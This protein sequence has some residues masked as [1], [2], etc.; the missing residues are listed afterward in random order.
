MPPT[1][2][3][4]LDEKSAE[5]MCCLFHCSW[6]K[7]QLKSR[8]AYCFIA[9]GWKGQILYPLTLS[10]NHVSP[11]ISLQ[12]DEKS[13]NIIIMSSV[14]INAELKSCILDWITAI[15]MLYR[16][17]STLS[18]WNPVSSTVSLQL[19]KQKTN[20]KR[21]MYRLTLRW[22]HVSSTVSLHLGQKTECCPV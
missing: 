10:W 17:T 4:Q 18:G 9:A 5:I 20:K 6:T 14:L 12:G 21:M 2:S 22:N 13:A 15:Q 3:L 8:V 1:V 16:L 11:T 19:G 7:S